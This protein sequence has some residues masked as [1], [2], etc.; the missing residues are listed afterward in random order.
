[1]GDRAPLR[2]PYS[3]QCAALGRECP[4]LSPEPRSQGTSS[5]SAAAT[6]L[7]LFLFTM[8]L[9]IL[10]W[11][12]DCCTEFRSP[13]EGGDTEGLAATRTQAAKPIPLS[14]WLGPAGADQEPG[15][16][17]GPLGPCRAT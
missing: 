4:G 6:A 10:Y 15:M 5:L 7:I 11:H 12:R 14:G 3:L 2:G 16:V 8:T 17:T 13:R 9:K 1:M